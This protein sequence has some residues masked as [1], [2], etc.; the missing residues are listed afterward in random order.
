MPTDVTDENKNIQKRV[1][2]IPEGNLW[3]LWAAVRDPDFERSDA[4][5]AN[6]D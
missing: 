5:N 3:N 6:A 1:M 2:A 4:S